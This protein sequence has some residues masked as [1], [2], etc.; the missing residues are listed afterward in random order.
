MYWQAR[1]IIVEANEAY[2]SGSFLLD[3]GNV[4]VEATEGDKDEGDEGEMEMDND[5]NY[6]SAKE[7][8]RKSIGKHMGCMPQADMRQQLSIYC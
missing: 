2:T 8:E 5:G 7:K 6:L 3:N 4:V 1:I